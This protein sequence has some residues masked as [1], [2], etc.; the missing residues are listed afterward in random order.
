MVQNLLCWRGAASL[1]LLADES[2]YW[3]TAAH[4]GMLEVP[5]NAFVETRSFSQP[6][7]FVP[8]AIQRSL[9]H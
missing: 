4:L 9:N 5:A 1:Y 2:R 6:V 8:L 7:L 3:A